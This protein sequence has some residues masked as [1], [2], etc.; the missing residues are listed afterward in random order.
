MLEQYRF[1]ELRQGNIW[2]P[3][4]TKVLP[5]RRAIRC[6]AINAT[7][8]GATVFLTRVCHM[9]LIFF[10]KT[11]M[12]IH[13]LGQAG[14]SYLQPQSKVSGAFGTCGN[15]Q[16]KPE[17]G[18]TARVSK[19]NLKLNRVL[20]KLTFCFNYVVKGFPQNL[21][22]QQKEHAKARERQLCARNLLGNLTAR[23]NDPKAM[24]K[25]VSLLEKLSKKMENDP[26][27]VPY[28]S[29]E[30]NSLSHADIIALRNGV[31][32]SEDGMD[33]LLDQL[34]SDGVRTE[35]ESMLKHISDNVKHRFEQEIVRKPFDEIGG[36]LS[37]KSVDGEAL[38][39]PL[40]KLAESMR[41]FDASLAAGMKGVGKAPGSY[42]GLHTC[43]QSLPESLR[44][45]LLILV[46]PEKWMNTA[47]ALSLVDN[48]KQK[49]ESISMLND[50]RIVLEHEIDRRAEPT[51]IK[52]EIALLQA[53]HKGDSLAASEALCELD[54]LI[55]D[56][57]E[58]HG[59]F[60]A[61]TAEDVRKLISASLPVFRGPSPNQQGP[62]DM[63]SLS[64]LD[65]EVLNN[66]RRAT[67]LRDLGLEL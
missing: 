34:S 23:A 53:V 17:Q 8:A 44:T 29:N 25:V 15:L 41:L 52:V 63:E 62:L 1:L 31:L 14:F 21:R 67:H 46:R 61:K 11:I 40:L 6:A 65:R 16:F 12:T 39:K 27:K 36:L 24:P 42:D 37:A 54:D 48:G 59:R 35:A 51:L 50:I 9:G 58:N 10:R 47:D 55:G 38:E 4:V 32:S 13:S 19:L 43:F 49:K 20:E 66:L 5:G 26:K 33:A 60:P 18:G 3:S 28:L 45:E 57:I 7:V 22:T 30:L 56:M 64:S 2:Y